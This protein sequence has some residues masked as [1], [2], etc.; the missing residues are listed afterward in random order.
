MCPNGHLCYVI[1]GCIYVTYATRYRSPES[2]KTQPR[3]RT[4][5][6]IRRFARCRRTVC[7]RFGCFFPPSLSLSPTGPVPEGTGVRW[8]SQGGFHRQALSRIGSA[9]SRVRR[10][11]RRVLE[12]NRKPSLARGF[13]A[14]KKAWLSELHSATPRFTTNIVSIVSSLRNLNKFTNFWCPQ[15]VERSDPWT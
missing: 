1:C 9:P 7:E 10:P 6:P 12:R 3:A 2:R 13:A 15:S 4:P 5:A 8:R 14:E 11:H